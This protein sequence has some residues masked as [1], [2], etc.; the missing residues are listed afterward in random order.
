MQNIIDKL[1]TLGAYAV[2]TVAVKDIKFDRG[3]RAMCESNSCGK[4]GKNYCCPPD[5]GAIDDLIAEARGYD[6]AIVYQTVGEIEDSYD[7]EGMMDIGKKHGE[8]VRSARDYCKENMDGELLFLGAG[9]CGECEVC[10]KL[11][12]EPCRFPDYAMKSLE[13]YGIAVSELAKKS[14]M[15]YINGQNTVTYFGAVLYK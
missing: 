14:G 1:K 10:G 11:T 15:K 5:A 9:G 12:N 4:Y 8:L 6:T 7:F 3:F 2:G 13:T